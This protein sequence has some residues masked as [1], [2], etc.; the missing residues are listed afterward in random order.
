MSQPAQDL[1]PEVA[2]TLED[3]EVARIP[4]DVSADRR[5]VLVA[6][7]GR[8]GTSLMSG[9]LKSIGLH[10][11]EPEVVADST[12]PK[13]FGEP[14]WVVDFHDLLL[15]RAIVHP[16]DAR[17][18][19]WFDA[20]RVSGREAFRADLTTWLE[21]QFAVADQ[22]VIKDPRLAWFLSLWR[23][24]AVRAGASTSIVTML[25]PPAEV[26]ASKNKYY[27]GRL[28]DISRLAGWTNMMLYTERATRGSRRTFVRYHDLLDD[29]TSTIVRAGEEIELDSITH[30][31][32]DRM[33]E[34]HNFVDPALHRVRS[35]WE[36]LSVPQPLQEVAEATWQ[37]LNKL[38]EPG[39]DTPD[40]REELDG[41]RR[42]YGDLY[43]EAEALTSSTAEAA[44]PT[45]L[46]SVRRAREQRAAE[47]V[48][49]ELAEASAARRAAVRARGIAG[50]AKRRLQGQGG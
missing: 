46:R 10:V 1:P 36:D 13:G 29:W 26:V 37:Q 38:A 23:V 41:L 50:R 3:L 39:G 43:A 22:L 25:R 48:A 42:V 9:I 14:Q 32:I 18:G 4:E 44:G 40:V 33:K 8:S 27:G 11:P 24:A 30:A 21:E 2:L 31:G 20:G 19:A 34:V 7:S 17:P 49:A 28:G 6:G 35:G 45:F 5:I 15:R 16:S 12:N 47:A